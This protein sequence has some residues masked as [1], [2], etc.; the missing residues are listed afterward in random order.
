M[1]RY[2]LQSHSIETMS[3]FSF[4]LSRFA[5]DDVCWTYLEEYLWPNGPIC[6]A[7]GSVGDATRWKPRPHHWQCYYRR[8]GGKPCG[9]QFHAAYGT[10]MQGSHLPKRKWFE[11]IFLLST[12]PGLS[13]VALGRRLD[14][15]QK[16]AWLVARRLRQNSFLERDLASD[17]VAVVEGRSPT[18]RSSKKQK[19]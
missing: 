2:R 16:T 7:C 9:K 4:D 3:G 1:S 14:V 10:P 15:G 8:R 12:S 18:A 13:T 11:A 19:R 17:I 6:P 5:D